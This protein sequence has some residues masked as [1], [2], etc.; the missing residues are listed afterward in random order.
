MICII[1]FVSSLRPIR[2][3]SLFSRRNSGSCAL[4]QSALNARP[5]RSLSLTP[6][7]SPLLIEQLYR[8]CRRPI[9]GVLAV[10]DRDRPPPPPSDAA[11]PTC[12]RPVDGNV[13]RGTSDL[14]IYLGV[15]QLSW[16][17]M[18]QQNLHANVLSASSVY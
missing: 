5:P 7:R 12:P 10:R 1:L 4:L 3:M 2:S 14:E 17:F 6:S 15:P 13:E 16:Q 11:E 9:P 8:G 18:F